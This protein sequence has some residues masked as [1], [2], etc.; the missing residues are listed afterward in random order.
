MNQPVPA[1]G[2]EKS[3]S[4]SHSSSSEET[5]RPDSDEEADN[6]TGE[7]QEDD[8][9]VP[10]MDLF[11]GNFSP[12]PGDEK[13]PRSKE[14]PVFDEFANFDVLAGNPPLPESSTKSESSLTPD[15]DPFAPVPPPDIDDFEKEAGASDE[16][17][18]GDFVGAVS[19]SIADA[20][21]NE[22]KMDSRAEEADFI[23]ASDSTVNAS[24]K[25]ETVD[26]MDP[27]SFDDMKSELNQEESQNATRVFKTA[28]S[29][30]SFEDFAHLETAPS[31]ELAADQLTE[32]PTSKELASSALPDS[33]SDDSSPKDDCLLVSSS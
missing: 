17:G 10:V 29:G 25:P 22:S 9:S 2:K 4:D 21:S 14:L 12:D 31:D 27:F 15:Q 32:D 33:S 19:T 7:D 6:S 26:A 1:E 5:P 20:N 18:F 16:D 24:D 13:P 30:A 28:F 23:T 8:D 3:E 11:A